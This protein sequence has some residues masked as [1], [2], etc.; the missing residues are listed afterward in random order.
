MSGGVFFRMA[1][2]AALTTISNT[3]TTAQAAIVLPDFGLPTIMT[4]LGE[5]EPGVVCPGVGCGVAVPAGGVA[6]LAD[7]VA[8]EPGVKLCPALLE[9]PAGGAPPGE[10]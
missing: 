8:G 2:N 5:A 7:G 6:V 9:P 10:L 1:T 3:R 4:A